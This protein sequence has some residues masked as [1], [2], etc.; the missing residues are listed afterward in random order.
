MEL[1]RAMAKKESIGMER[2]IE[3][4]LE[5]YGQR[6]NSGG[7]N[8][9]R[10]PAG[11]VNSGFGIRSDPLTGEER[12]HKRIDIAAPEGTLIRAA[13]SGT[14]I[15]SGRANSYG[16]MIVVDH[17]NGLVTRYAHTKM[18]LL[19]TGDPVQAGQEI[20]LVGTTGRSTGPHLHFEVLRR[21]KAVD[22]QP[23]LTRI[24]ASGKNDFSP[25]KSRIL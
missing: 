25:L 20:A 5:S 22:P 24:A 10:S 16:N 23:F 12:F 3:K 19:S 7:T 9:I 6:S 2:L 17:G 1:A 13:A 11:V 8:H 15:Y 14:I 21:G 18:N 4:A